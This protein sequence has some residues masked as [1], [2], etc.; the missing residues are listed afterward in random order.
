METSASYP[1]FTSSCREVEKERNKHDLSPVLVVAAESLTGQSDVPLN[2]G[3]RPLPR[4]ARMSFPPPPFYRCGGHKC[5]REKSTNI[6]SW[7][8]ARQAYAKKS[9]CSLVGSYKIWP[10]HSHRDAKKAYICIMFVARLLDAHV[11][12]GFSESK[13]ND[14]KVLFSG[15]L[16]NRARCNHVPPWVGDGLLVREG[17]VELQW[18][19]KKKYLLTPKPMLTYKCLMWLTSD[20]RVSSRFPLFKISWPFLPHPAPQATFCGTSA[21]S[22]LEEEG[23]A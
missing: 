13:R 1:T 16:L 17:A 18:S 20:G 11:S 21:C 9:L 15:A 8:S 4:P 2:Q 10:P 19:S 23:Q 7:V 12:I 5:R 6:N 14:A 22:C 3:L